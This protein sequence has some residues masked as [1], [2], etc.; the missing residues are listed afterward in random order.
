MKKVVGMLSVMTLVSCGK[1]LQDPL[2]V[3]GD[4][5]QDGVKTARIGVVD[6]FEVAYKGISDVNETAKKGLTDA[7]RESDEF[8]TEQ[9]QL[10]D[11]NGHELVKR[12]GEFGEGIGQVP[13]NIGN[14]LL[15][16]ETEDDLSG[17][18]DRVDGIEERL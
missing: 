18:E 6:S 15:G 13:R 10:L 2:N 8:L 3:A 7:K 9:K 12:V 1:T 4:M 17:L 11:N 5:I 14:A 16:T